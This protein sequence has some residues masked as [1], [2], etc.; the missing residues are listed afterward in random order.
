MTT[1]MMPMV[2][3]T[4][5]AASESRELEASQAG[6][7]GLSRVAKLAKKAARKLAKKLET[8]P[9]RR[10]RVGAVSKPPV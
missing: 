5:K 9:V 4:P 3:E 7:L 6:S 2:T 1:K 10:R 8:S